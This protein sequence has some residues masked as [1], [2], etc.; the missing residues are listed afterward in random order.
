MTLPSTLKSISER[1]ERSANVSNVFGEPIVTEGK[2]VIP[3]AKVRYGFGGG[4]G[5]G[6]GSEGEGEG[7]GGG[8]GGGV[9]VTAVGMIEITPE[10]TRYISFEDRGRLIK[11]GLVL[12]LIA[13]FLFIRRLRRRSPK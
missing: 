5:K 8:G 6:K 13:T 10:E 4:F 7:Q 11:A 12:A 3:V 9:E 2:T 1:F